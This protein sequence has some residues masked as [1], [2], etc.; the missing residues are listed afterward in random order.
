MPPAMRAHRNMPMDDYKKFDVELKLPIEIEQYERKIYDLKQLIEISKGLNST[1]EYNVLI[2]S[3]L[4]TCM[5]QMQLFKAGIFLKKGLDVDLY[6]LH[7]NYKGFELNHQMEY[8]IPADSKLILFLEQNFRCYTLRELN[9]IFR[10]ST[11]EVLNIIQPMLVVPLKGKGKLNGLIILG[12]RISSQPFTESEKEYLLNISSLAGIAIQNAYLYEMATTDMMTKLKIHHY[13]QAALAEE[14]EKSLR[15]KSPLSLL[16]MDIDHF[17]KFNDTY[18]HT[19]GDEVLK[20]VARIVVSNIRQID[21]AARYG[22]EEFSVILPGTTL[23]DAVL[24]AERIRRCVEQCTV[25]CD[26]KKLSVMISVGATQ[27][28]PVKDRDTRALIQRA[29]HALYNSK[30]AGR[31]RVSFL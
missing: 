10:D 11:M 9:E 30:Q 17:K 18:G 8:E 19:C 25:N 28:D 2:E 3:I 1:L 21:V 15:Q 4:L 29:D 14:R 23:D 26:D 31:N 24:V 5:G 12:E 13:F 20:S 16:M 22:G 7:R 27:F 6:V